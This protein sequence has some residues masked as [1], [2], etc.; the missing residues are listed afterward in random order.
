MKWFI[1]LYLLIEPANQ[2]VERVVIPVPFNKYVD[3]VVEGLGNTK[4][5]NRTGYARCEQLKGPK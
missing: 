2:N 1:V 5:G 4:L 3:C